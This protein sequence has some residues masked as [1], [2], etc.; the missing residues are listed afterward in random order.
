[1]IGPTNAQ[2]P[3]ELVELA[4]S[5]ARAK[6]SQAQL[7]ASEVRASLKAPYV[8]DA[9]NAPQVQH[10]PPPELD[11]HGVELDDVDSDFDKILG[12]LEGLFQAN[13]YGDVQ[14]LFDAM[15]G[16][17]Q[18]TTG[19]MASALQQ[20]KRFLQGQLPLGVGKAEAIQERALNRIEQIGQA[21]T[22]ALRSLYSAN[23]WPV[24]AGAMRAATG[25]IE[26]TTQEQQTDFNR[27]FVV[28]QWEAVLNGLSSGVQA[29]LSAMRESLGAAIELAR[30][31][32]DHD[33]NKD[34]LGLERTKL[35]V[36]QRLAQAQ[37]AFNRSQVEL[38]EAQLLIPLS[39]IDDAAG[40]HT[41]DARLRLGLWQ[42]QVDLAAD[43]VRGMGNIS[44]AQINGSSAG[45]SIDADVSIV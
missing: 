10:E 3:E 25:E 23:R 39:E 24:P 36:L 18:P 16:S 35:G 1:M 31:K 41:A 20:C 33:P 43:K 27:A 14:A 2:T 28:A 17:L 45:A 22:M 15:R 4:L 6:L 37:L 12:K 13:T 29:M 38:A 7:Q 30:L 40:V 44:S 32:Q 34:A 21:D 26:R 19:A 9:D 42:A 11:L 5:V 8:L